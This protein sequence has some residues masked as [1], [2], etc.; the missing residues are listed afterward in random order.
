MGFDDSFWEAHQHISAASRRG[1]KPDRYDSLI[2]RSVAHFKPNRILEIGCGDVDFGERIS[3]LPLH[4]VG[5]DSSSDGLRRGRRRALPKC[6]EL[7][8]ANGIRLPFRDSAF[9][10][11]VMIAA[12]H[13]TGWDVLPEAR[14]VLR[15]GGLL[16]L[17]DHAVSDSCLAVAVYRLAHLMP[18]GFRRRGSLKSLYLDGVLP[19]T[20]EFRK[21]ELVSHLHASGLV[22]IRWSFATTG[23]TFVLQS[24]LHSLTAVFPALIG[25]TQPTFDILDSID[26]RVLNKTRQRGAIDFVVVAA[27]AST[28]TGQLGPSGQ[29]SP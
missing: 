23:P 24:A 26:I 13:H 20:L 25:A 19:T 17:N 22:P 27:E 11:V 21:E 9:D 18:P 8:R 5:I 2:Q 4:Y 10:V 12:L 29:P 16:I 28:R 1:A 3:S 15:K 7:V 14:T 6:A